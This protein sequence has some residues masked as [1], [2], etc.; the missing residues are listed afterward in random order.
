MISYTTIEKILDAIK[1]E[2]VIG[3]F[4]TLHRSGRFYKGLC[5]FHE[6]HT[7][8][9]TVT[10]SRNMFYCFG[11]KKGGDAVTFLMEHENMTYPEALKW[12]G[13]K[14][15][16]EVDEQEEGIEEKKKRLEKES[17]QIVNEAVHIFYREQFLQNKEAQKYAYSRW[18]KKYCDEIEIGY[19]PANGKALASLPHQ[20]ELMIELGLINTSGYDFYQNRIVIPIRSRF[21]KII[22]FTARS[23]DDTQP[24]YLN[25]KESLLY[26][27]RCSLFGLDVAWRGAGKDKKLYLVEGAP[28]CMRMHLLGMENTVASLGSSW[29]DE[30]FQL[31][32]RAASKIC[33]LPDDDP[34]KDGKSFGTGIETVMKA[35]KSAM[36][37]HLSVSVKEIP[38]DNHQG[39]K[40]PDSY[41]TDIDIFRKTEEVDYVLWMADKL[42]PLCENTEQK[43]DIIKRLAYLLSLIDDETKVSLYI[44]S[45][46]KYNKSKIIWKKAI[47]FACEQKDRDSNEK[48]EIDLN[49]KY[50]FWIEHGKYFSS[51]E[52]NG[53]YEWS[54][55]TMQPLF[56]IKDSIMAKRIYTFKNELGVEEL[57]EMRQED[58]ISLQKF[59]QKIE[60]LGNF[61]WKAGDRELTKLKCYLYENT[62]TAIEVKQLGWNRKEFYAFGNGVFYDGRF[63]SVDDYGIVRL[64][65]KG[66]YYLP[67]YS[68]IYK[69]KTD[70]FKFERRFVHL[71]FSTIPLRD[72]T[73]QIF[74]VFGDNGKVAFCF[75]LATLFRD[76]ITMT[77]RS[78]PILNLFGPKGS[79][80]TELGHTLL[81]LL[82]I[83]NIPPNIQNSTIP[84]LND[85]VAAVSDGLVHIDEYKNGI[86]PLKIEFLKGLWDGT[87]RTRMN[88]DLD[89]K[90]ETTA[91]DAGIILSGQEM[92]TADIALFSRLIFLSF[93]KSEFTTEEKADYQD[94]LQMRSKGMT[95]LTIGI[96]ARRKDVAASFFDTFQTTCN[97]LNEKFIDI[98]VMDRIILNWSIPLTAYRCLANNIDV[99]L[100][101]KEMFNI[102]VEGIRR[103]NA[104]C[105]VSDEIG[106]FWRVVQFL[107]SEGEIIEDGDFKIRALARFHSDRFK[108]VHWNEPRKILY[109]QKTRIF[110]LYKQNCHKIG[111]KIL[112]EETLKYY[113]ENSKCFLGEQRMTYHVF[114]KGIQVIDYEHHDGL[115]GPVK[116]SVQQ[117]S[118]CFDYQ[119]LSDTF[120]INLEL[121]NTETSEEEQHP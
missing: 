18:N 96:L 3:E 105:R 112:P 10:P 87:G 62:E 16:I 8:S 22:G 104:E 26:S 63:M 50:G 58:L 4:V 9:F 98:P 48:H 41:Y 11:C 115:N 43:S 15:G 91:V 85:T 66:N 86:D 21:Q 82:M 24:K 110:M 46:T 79:G 12:L 93:S 14:Y 101:Y 69:E 6:E 88:M 95:H 65:E 60:S 97:E 120:E 113:L 30:Q 70:L 56:H 74:K 27:K 119:L 103:Q 73:A 117:R 7:P 90:K 81:S 114:K 53:I 108:D 55:F 32:S 64:G 80:K 72:F 94:L 47:E 92:P 13:R 59:K 89:K 61:I 44:N 36:E 19:A 33:F 31:I 107:V 42:F 40:D 35:G 111:D 28:D 34:P 17:L 84:A 57:V 118:Y 37:H 75:Y 76:I 39:K 109:L 77:T 99:P 1:I 20:K 83:E 106:A 29:T 121:G 71:N 38:D 100:T 5:P 67:A 116:K 52:K 54:N 23:L 102:T 2:D 78:F 49:K 45:L 51:S 68:K 25:S